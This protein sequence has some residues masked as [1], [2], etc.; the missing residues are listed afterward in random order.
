MTKILIPHGTSPTGFGIRQRGN[1]MLRPLSPCCGRSMEQ[2]NVTVTARCKGCNAD[3]TGAANDQGCSLGN[4]VAP[5]ID[6]DL[7]NGWVRKVTGYETATVS[8]V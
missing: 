1:G 2:I 7:L 4:D 5:T 6:A 3:Y 8:V